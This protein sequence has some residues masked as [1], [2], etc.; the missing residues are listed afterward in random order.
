MKAI[1]LSDVS[2]A[3][4]AQEKIILRHLID[5]GQ[6]TLGTAI[7]LLWGDREDG[8]P[9]CA[10]RHVRILMWRI[11]EGLRPGWCI[12]LYPRGL[13]RLIRVTNEAIAA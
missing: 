1:L 2:S 12:P 4:A 10:D 9:L 5:R 7:S 13:W 3:T 11:R 6:I 8:G